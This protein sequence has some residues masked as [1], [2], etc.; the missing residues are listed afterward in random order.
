M[1]Q[2][3]NSCTLN[4]DREC[5]FCLS[6]EIVQQ[7]LKRLIAALG[8]D[9]KDGD[10]EKIRKERLNRLREVADGCPACMLATI[11]QADKSHLYVYYFRDVFSIKK[12]VRICGKR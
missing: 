8:I 4:P 2:H 5:K 3:E 12:K 10:T 9:A 1:E 7:P 11:R 6:L